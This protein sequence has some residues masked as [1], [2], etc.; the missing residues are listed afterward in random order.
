MGGIPLIKRLT[1]LLL[2]FLLLSGCTG[3]SMQEDKTTDTTT[4][5]VLLK[6]IDNPHWQEMRKGI[7]DT[8]AARGVDIILLYPESETNTQ[9]QSLIF[10]DILEQQ[11]DA[12]LW[13]PCDSSLGPQMKAMADAAGVPLF[14]V[15][16]RADGV[17]L[18]YIGADNLRIGR[19]AAQELAQS[20]DYRGKFAVI[21]GPQNQQCHVE[22][23]EGFVQIMKTFPDIEVVDICYPKSE[24]GF[25]PA[26]DVMQRLLDTYPDLSGVFCTSGVIGLGAAEQIKANYRQEQVLVVTQDTQSDVLSAVNTGLV[27]AMVTQDGYEAGHLAINTILSYLSGNEIKQNIY[28]SAELLTWR[29]VDDFMKDYLQRRD[30]HD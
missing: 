5:A 29:N 14:T 19:I 22:R 16:T 17:D 4:I 3:S 26:M 1:G 8:A 27:H 28:L 25:I 21:A 23:A 12:L 10:Q 24:Y 18:P 6:G 7:L 15:D 2:T 9:Q 30:A 20:S 13:A 11:P